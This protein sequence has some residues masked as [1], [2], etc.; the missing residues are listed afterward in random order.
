MSLGYPRFR[1][2]HPKACILSATYHDGCS[3]PSYPNSSKISTPWKFDV[4][5][6]RWCFGKGISFPAWLFNRLTEPV[7]LPIIFYSWALMDN[8]HKHPT[9]PMATTGHHRTCVRPKRGPTRHTW[10]TWTWPVKLRECRSPRFKT[11]GSLKIMASYV[12]KGPFF[13]KK[14]QK[15]NQGPQLDTA[16]V[17]SCRV[18]YMAPW[19]SLKPIDCRQSKPRKRVMSIFSPLKRRHSLQSL[20]R[21]L[22]FFGCSMIS[23]DFQ[24]FSRLSCQE[25]KQFW[26]DIVRDL[27]L[28]FWMPK[29]LP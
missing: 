14:K 9:H 2:M 11:S 12:V 3:L 18:C 24:W 1:T 16:Q 19:I 13:I 6:S 28:P 5:R 21:S 26:W 29:W 8:A 4:W 23:D 17:V 7:N 25:S 10:Y 22:L 27:D 15:N 20:P